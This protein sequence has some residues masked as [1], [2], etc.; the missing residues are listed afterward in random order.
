MI[1]ITRNP[2]DM[3]C[4]LT[5]YLINCAKSSSKLVWAPPS[6]ASAAPERVLD[7][8]LGLLLTRRDK[9][10]PFV[11]NVLDFW[12]AH[13]RNPNRLLFLHYEQ[14]VNNGL[15][16]LRRI[17]N[18]LGG[19]AAS[20]TDSDIR[21][22][23]ERNEIDNLRTVMSAKRR[24]N[25]EVPT[26]HYYNKGGAGRWKARWSQKQSDAIEAHVQAALADDDDFAFMYE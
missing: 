8:L 19:S 7:A 16:T 24:Q 11:E 2:K 21:Q 15:A 3:L 25:V 13:R 1:Y 9:T 14:L 4:S 10:G 18:F 5:D 20:L 6:L 22:V 23:L 12:R 26:A 17:A